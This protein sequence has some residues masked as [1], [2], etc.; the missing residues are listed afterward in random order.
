VPV[1]PLIESDLYRAAHR[2]LVQNRSRARMGVRRSG[3]LLQGLLA[4]SECRYAY[5][6]KTTRQKGAGGRVRD[7]IYYR[8]SGT[9]GYRFGGE[10]ICTNP[11]ITGKFIEPSVWTEVCTLLKNPLRLEHAFQKKVAV[12][13]SPEH[14]EILKAKLSKLQRGL[15]R[16]IDTYSEGAIEKEQFTPRLSR[17]KAQI[18]EL[19]AGIRAQ[20]EGADRRQELQSLVDHFRKLANH[21]GPGV[22]NADWDRRREIIRSLV[23]RVDIGL[24]D[25]MIV[26]RVPQ[27]TAV[28]TTDPVVVKLPRP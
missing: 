28:S 14:L 4:C 24:A 23:E 10:R 5:Y 9:D 20:A 21:L 8:C 17:T 2:Q 25:L 19:E 11:Q 16:L 7:F 6:G 13:S 3:Y 15:E 18:A 27:G 12:G 1:P 26:F 22:E